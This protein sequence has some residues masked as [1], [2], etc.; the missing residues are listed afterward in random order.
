M[1]FVPDENQPAKPVAAAGAALDV[2]GVAKAKAATDQLL[3]AAKTGGFRISEQGVAPLRKA[4]VDMAGRLDELNA[5]TI[6][7]LSQAPKLGSHEYG[8]TVAAH[9]Q[10]AAAMD[11]N[12]A[13]M[14][15]DQFRQVLSDADEALA[16]AAGI[17][18][19]SEHAAANNMGSG[20]D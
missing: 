9:D 6:R 11:P 18:R 1:P 10:K 12:S 5:L 3:R 20:R 2:G 16:R 14:V 15:L 19:E 7:R 4:L 13:A 17:Y 8:G